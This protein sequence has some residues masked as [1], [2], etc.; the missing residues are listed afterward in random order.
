MGGSSAVPSRSVPINALCFSEVTV[1]E[2][3]NREAL[4]DDGLRRY[5]EDHACQRRLRETAESDDFAELVRIEHFHFY[6]A[7]AVSAQCVFS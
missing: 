4:I 3:E 7:Q 2:R 1:N 6:S 5:P